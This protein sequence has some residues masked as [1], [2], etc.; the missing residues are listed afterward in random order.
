M[1]AIIFLARGLLVVPFALSGQREWHTP[2]G[3][4]VVAGQWFVA[5][6]LVVLLIGALIGLGLY[7]TRSRPRALATGEALAG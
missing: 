3:L 2:L 1:L 5:G 7:Q 6:S 4:F